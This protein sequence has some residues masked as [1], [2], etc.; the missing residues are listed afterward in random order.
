LAELSA[1]GLVSE[2][3][4]VEGSPWAVGAGAPETTMI[5]GSDGPLHDAIAAKNRVTTAAGIIGPTPDAGAPLSCE[6]CS[7]VIDHR[8]IAC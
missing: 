3:P 1:E 8:S 5:C 7:R 2:A 4:P 6:K